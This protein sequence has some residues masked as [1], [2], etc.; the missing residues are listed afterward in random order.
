MYARCCFGLK[1]GE[2]I[3]T[4][5]CMC[6]CVCFFFSFL[7]RKCDRVLSNVIAALGFDVTVSFVELQMS[8][9]GPEFFG[10]GGR[11]YALNRSSSLSVRISGALCNG[12]NGFFHPICG[13]GLPT[14]QK[15]TR[16]Y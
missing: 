1:T 3:K 13:R 6:V 14:T 4:T 16:M 8:L 11:C 2:G 12:T 10:E 15:R 9:L 5:V 7:R